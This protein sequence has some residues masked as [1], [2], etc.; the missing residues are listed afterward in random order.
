MRKSYRAVAGDWLRRPLEVRPDAQWR[1]SDLAAIRHYSVKIFLAQLDG[2]LELGHGFDD[3]Q[4][5]GGRL[6]GW[7]VRTFAVIPNHSAVLLEL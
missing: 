5:R 4:R 7:V 6:V 3:L 2:K 1:C